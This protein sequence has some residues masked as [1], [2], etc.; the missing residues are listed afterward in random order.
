MPSAMSPVAVPPW[1]IAILA[2]CTVGFWILLLG[3]RR[4]NPPI[5][6]ATIAE[7]EADL[8]SIAG[9]T[10]GSI[11]EGNAVEILQN[12]DGFFPV[13]LR[14]IAGA[15]HSIHLETFVWQRGEICREIG[16][17]LAKRA[18]DGVEVRVLVDAMGAHTR[19]RDLFES[20]KQAGCKVAVYCPLR[21]Q[22]LR[23][24]NHR[25][26]RKV[27][28]VDGR[29]G[30]V[31]GHGIG[32]QWT[33][34]GQDPDHYRDTALRVVGPVVHSLQSVF[35]ENWIEETLELTIGD[36]YFPPLEAAGDV[37]AHVVSSSGEAISSVGL[38]YNVAIASARREIIIQNPYFVPR[39]DVVEL[40]ARRLEEGVA[41][42][43]M[44]PGR[45]TDHAL[46]RHAGHYLVR[47]MLEAGVRVYEY[48]RSLLHQKT[49]IVD[50][51]WAHVGSTNFDARSLELSEELSI[52]VIDERIAAELKGAFVA[53]LKHARE[54]TLRQWSHRSAWHRA[55]DG[56]AY[57][58]RDQL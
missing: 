28:V 43:V 11:W 6:L 12:G 18:K 50:E 58:I 41:I 19:D 13:L 51:T 54:L 4:R 14:D 27:L 26:H 48:D 8:P 21:P 42:H 3:S 47:G 37:K 25:T 55:M 1:L 39:W 22:N 17:A 29:I 49:M 57:A 53:D 15:R 31:F 7:V 2:L 40:M 5:T 10:R 9:I 33:G 45:N 20:M 30:V 56:A 44:L 38:L 34:N 36:E 35:T 16:N 52:G 32:Q 24:W 46:V 23:R